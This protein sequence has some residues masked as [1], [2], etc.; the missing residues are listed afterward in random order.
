[1]VLFYNTKHKVCAA[2]FS[3]RDNFF[4]PEYNYSISGGLKNAIDL[5]WGRRFPTAQKPKY[6]Q[7]MPGKI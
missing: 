2:A 4:T 7:Q 1:M 5:H 3:W 6:W